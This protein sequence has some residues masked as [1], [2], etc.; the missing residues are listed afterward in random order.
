MCRISVIINQVPCE[1]VKGSSINDVTALGGEGINDFVTIE[2][3]PCNKTRDDGGRGVKN[4]QILRDVIYGRPLRETKKVEK[5]CCVRL[6]HFTIA[7]NLHNQLI[8]R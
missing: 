2:L 8:F 5:H 1:G 6:K 3:K 7:S 4:Y